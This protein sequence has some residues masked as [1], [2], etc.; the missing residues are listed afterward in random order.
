VSRWFPII[1]SEYGD[2]PR[3]TFRVDE[4]PFTGCDE[5][6][7]LAIVEISVPGDHLIEI[8]V[9]DGVGNVQ[10]LYH[11]VRIEG[12]VTPQKA[13]PPPELAATLTLNRGRATA[14]GRHVFLPLTGRLIPRGA[15]TLAQVCKGYVRINVRMARKH[16]LVRR[17][18]LR[19][20]GSNCVYSVKARVRKRVIQRNRRVT[21]VA[22]SRTYG[23]WLVAK[24]Q[25]A[26]PQLT[27]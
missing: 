8:R 15:A 6:R 26:V 20:K 17:P 11:R 27:R 12:S 3:C 5:G 7:G 22:K 14:S 24:R 1:L 23:R 18:K 2:R 9:V 10:T 16:Y 25:F 13:D 19:R 4:G 21:A